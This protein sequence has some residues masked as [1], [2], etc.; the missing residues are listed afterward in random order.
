MKRIFEL[1]KNDVLTMDAKTLKETIR[2]SEGRSI[3]AE[4]VVCKRAGIEDVT[5]AEVSAAFGADMIMLNM[6][7]M[8]EPFIYGLDPIKLDPTK[9]KA[10]AHLEEWN[11]QFAEDIH[12][13][14]CI[15][16]LKEYTGRFIGSNMEPIPDGIDYPKGQKASKENFQRAIDLG[17][18][19]ISITGNPQ[20]A[21]TI[22]GI[23]RAVEEAK[24][25]VGD[26]VLIVAGKM[27]GAGSGNVYDLKEIERIISAGADVLLSGAPG[28]IPGYSVEFVRDIFAMAHA[29]GALGLSCIGT[30]QES[31]PIRYI[32]DFA[33]MSK[34]AGAD[35]VHLGDAGVG[36]MA[37]P[38]NVFEISLALRGERHTYRRMALRR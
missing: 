36:W 30:S 14:D 26:N 15:R 28:C 21:I 13:T 2:I 8:Q 37:P 7:D 10:R 9:S 27:H 5:E 11:R 23:V 18:D 24:N 6:F 25:V 31:S 17:M 3:M 22:D 4:N 1:T 19:F 12:K 38:M 16:R 29:N 35:I 33:I 34:M 32:K 20:T